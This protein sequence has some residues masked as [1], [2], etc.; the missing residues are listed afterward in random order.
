MF[1]VTVDYAAKCFFKCC[2]HR[3]RKTISQEVAVC[4]T[5]YGL[6]WVTWVLKRLDLLDACGYVKPLLFFI[7]WRS[8]RETSDMFLKS[9]GHSSAVFMLLAVC[10]SLAA[11]GMLIVFRG[12]Y[13][14][15]HTMNGF[16]EAFVEMFVFM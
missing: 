10:V 15:E 8:L 11:I 6:L 7:R 16:L 14:G 1:I 2:R 4:G 12:K 3:G 9:I 13:E 5:I